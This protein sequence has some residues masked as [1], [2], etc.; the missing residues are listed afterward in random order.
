M[1]KIIL[2]HLGKQIDFNLHTRP[3]VISA[4]ITS[5]KSFFELNFLEFIRTNYG[6]QKSIID[7][8]ANIGNH[9][10]FFS[11]FLVNDKVYCFEPDAENLELLRQNMSGRNCEIFDVA[12][13]N[14]KGTANIYSSSED[15]CG[16]YSLEIFDTS[17]AAGAPTRI[18]DSFLVKSGV[19]IRTLDSY[20]LQNISMIKIDVENHELYVLHG[21]RKT[22]LK[23]KPIVFVED[24]HYLFPAF[25][26][27]RFHQFFLSVGYI[28]KETNIRGLYTDLWVPKE[29]G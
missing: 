2:Q 3:D 25:P 27:E 4:E 10:L 6:I 20:N 18:M 29:M 17:M 13:S 23:N 19:P 15:N 16:A 1:N 24:L 26:A 21:A 7:I 28:R 11:E 5:T 12:L 14:R 8:G 22:I 9:S